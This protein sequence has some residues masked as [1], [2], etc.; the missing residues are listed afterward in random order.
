MAAEGTHEAV[1]LDMAKL[2][3][4]KEEPQQQLYV[5][6]F[7]NTLERLV[8]R[9]DGDGASAYQLYVQKELFR[10][11]SLSAP[12]PTR[13]I[14]NVAGR[15]FAAIFD[16]GDRKLLFDTINELLNIINAGKSDKDLRTR[17]AA[18]HCLGDIYAAAGDSA[19]NLSSYAASSLLKLLKPSSN[20]SGLRASIFKALGKIYI[21]VAGM[22]DESIARDVYKQARNTSAGDKSSVV[23]AGALQV[24][25]RCATAFS[26]RWS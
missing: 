18:V 14:R 22:A 2:A 7:L 11:I 26:F 3:E 15:C 10:I 12:A 4:I 1:Q 19:G 17:H 13:L 5:L 23:Q 16:K 21:L 6:T 8:N 20:H 25:E 24:W 9:L